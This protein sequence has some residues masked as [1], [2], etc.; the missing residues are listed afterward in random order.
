MGST[1]WIVA[2]VSLF[3]LFFF[4]FFFYAIKYRLIIQVL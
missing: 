1:A 2:S 4:F 3:F